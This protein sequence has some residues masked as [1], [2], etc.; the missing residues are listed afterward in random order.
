[1]HSKLVE[2]RKFMEKE[3]KAWY[4]GMKCKRRRRILE[5][6]EGMYCKV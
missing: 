4:V 6:G 3:C 2:V 1:M 5:E